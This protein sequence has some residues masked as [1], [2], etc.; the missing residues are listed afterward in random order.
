MV[1]LIGSGIDRVRG[2]GLAAGV[3]L[4]GGFINTPLSVLVKWRS[5]HEG[6]LHQ[7]Y[8]NGKLVGVTS[9]CREQMLV[10]AIPSGDLA[11]VRI[12]VYAVEPSQGN[13]DFGEDIETFDQAGR[14]RIEWP[15]Y[16][17]LPFVGSAL[18]YSDGGEGNI[19]YDTAVNTEPIQLW[20]TWQDKGGFGLSRFARSDFGFDGSAAVGFG[21]GSFSYG[22]FGFDADLVTWDSCELETGVY[23]FGV[24]VMDRFGN[25]SC[26]SETEE[27]SVI[28]SAEPVEGFE[29][30]SYDQEQEELLLKLR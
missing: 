15:R 2:F 21:N 12:D 28:R 27:I 6:K 11:A 3:G 5:A 16:L 29:V 13:I 19:D 18:I 24:K 8:V 23:Q 7:V 20:S 9:N 22:E 1:S 10:A 4:D 25:Y 17:S 14:V 30:D 26:A